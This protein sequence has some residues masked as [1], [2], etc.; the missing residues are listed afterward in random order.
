M[1][2]TENAR[3]ERFGVLAWS[4]Q[5]ARHL[6]ENRMRAEQI[7]QV[8]GWIARTP[9]PVAVSPRNPYVWLILNRSPEGHSVLGLTNLSTGVYSSLRLYWGGAGVPQKISV[10]QD[11]G[12]LAEIDFHREEGAGILLRLDLPLLPAEL[13]VLVIED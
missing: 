9:L 7:R 4:G 6:L 3:G 8:V 2:L 13:A 1:L 11:D 12:S 10:L 5:G